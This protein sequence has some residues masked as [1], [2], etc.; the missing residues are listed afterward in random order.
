MNEY[1]TCCHCGGEKNFS[2]L[3]YHEDCERKW[4]AENGQPQVVGVICSSFTT[5]ERMTK[6]IQKAIKDAPPFS[7]IVVKC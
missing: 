5:K 3:P 7:S 4:R 2:F 6:A 1:T